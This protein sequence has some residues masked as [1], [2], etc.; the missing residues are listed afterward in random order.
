M[1][2]QAHRSFEMSGHVRESHLEIL[3]DWRG[4]PLSVDAHM[5]FALSLDR[6]LLSIDVEAPYYGDPAP[7]GPPGPRDGLWNYEVAELFLLGEDDVYL[8][9]ELGPH[10]H[11]LVLE[12]HGP[13]NVVQRLDDIAYS[14]ALRGGTWSGHAEIPA[15]WIPKPLGLGNAYGIHGIGNGRH[16][17]ALHPVPGEAPDFHRLEHFGPI[18][19]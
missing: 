7:N 17:A 9:I 12:L 16:Y 5:R 1:D 11:H 6:D 10:G 4:H 14:A 19:L 15:T 2:M 8:E 3:R 18:G 13:R